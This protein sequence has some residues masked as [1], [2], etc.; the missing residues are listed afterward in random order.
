MKGFMMKRMV[1]GLFALSALVWS[2]TAAQAVSYNFA[3]ITS[4]G[5]AQIASQLSV[6]VTVSG[7]N[8]SFEFFNN[9]GIASSI[10]EIYFD[11]GLLGV[12]PTIT[13]NGTN[14][15]TGAN[16]SNLPGGNTLTPP[17][18]A[19]IVFNAESVQQGGAA[20]NGVNAAGDS[21]TL[22]FG[23]GSFVDLAAVQAALANGSLRIGLHVISIAQPGGGNTSE[24][25]VNTVPE[26]SSTLLLGIALAGVALV[27]SR[28]LRCTTGLRDVA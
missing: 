21:V 4:N 9:V 8:V 13:N 10:T 24:A 20:A 14:F 22:T 16:P 5:T 27:G 12:P 3:Q 15:V 11:D 2:A 17:F 28:K 1:L 19:D 25:F 18:V 7:T 26:A 23:L 6:D